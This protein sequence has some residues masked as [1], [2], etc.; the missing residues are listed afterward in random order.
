[1]KRVP[2]L[3]AALCCLLSGCS[4]LP[5]EDEIRNLPLVPEY[6]TPAYSTVIVERGDLNLAQTIGCEYIRL[7]EE[8]LRFPIDGIAYG[9]FYVS[10]GQEVKAGQL[11]V[12]LDTT[13]LDE[14]IA[15]LNKSVQRIRLQL[16]TLEA[17]RTLALERRKLSLQG[18]SPE[19]L[20]QALA[21]VNAQYDRQ[22]ISLDDEIA[23]LELEIDG[24]KTQRRDYQL[25]AGMDG[26]VT[27]TYAIKEGAVSKSSVTMVTITDLSSSVFQAETEFWDHFSPGEIIYINSLATTIDSSGFISSAPM[28]YEATLATEQELGLPETEKIPGQKAE[29]YFR[30]S[31]P[32]T[33]ID[34]KTPTWIT[35]DLDSRKDV[36]LL[37]SNA[38]SHVDEKPIVYCLGD[39]GILE[40]RYIE[41][42]LQAGGYTEILSGLSEGDT[43]I[44]R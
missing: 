22:R 17:N 1:M 32:D 27:Y 10:V 33:P 41:T 12:E 25:Y 13:E 15:A 21:E 35:L 26:V 20:N 6:T 14:S 2:L 18:Q 24:Y 30:L 5:Q 16:D 23:L 19:R 11:L 37:P 39:G 9:Q 3:L 38:I 28:Y 44:Q 4:L 42:G 31:D 34:G 36:L 8:A 29:I 40:I 43:V 7:N